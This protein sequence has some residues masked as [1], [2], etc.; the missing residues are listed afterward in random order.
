MTPEEKK[1]RKERKAY[2]KAV[3]RLANRLGKHIAKYRD[4]SGR[5]L[6]IIEGF[7]NDIDPRFDP[8]AFEVAVEKHEMA[9]KAIEP[10][11]NN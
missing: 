5:L 4:G 3:G 10:R 6:A 7:C 11:E 1:E 9:N 8:E 2:L